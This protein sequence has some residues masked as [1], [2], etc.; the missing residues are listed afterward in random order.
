MAVFFYKGTRYD[1]KDES[2]EL[3]AA[4][5]QEARAQ[6]RARRIT[7]ITIKRKDTL[8]NRMKEIQIGTGVNAR[9][10]AAFTRQFATM[11][12]AGLPLMRC[13]RLV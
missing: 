12:N 13:M 10:M 3:T 9:S 5:I 1:G 6:L 11:I 4:N 7:P 8:L 2:G